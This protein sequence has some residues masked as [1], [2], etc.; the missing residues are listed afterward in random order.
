VVF[1]K[2]NIKLQYEFKWAINTIIT[3]MLL[4]RAEQYAAFEETIFSSWSP[5]IFS[6]IQFNNRNIIGLGTE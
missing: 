5:W 3:S 6:V 2:L 4:V 1:I